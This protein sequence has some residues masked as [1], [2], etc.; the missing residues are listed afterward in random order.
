MKSFWFYLTNFIYK[1]PGLSG[2]K[3]VKKNNYKKS[4]IEFFICL[5]ASW[6]PIILQILIRMINSEDVF[7]EIV[8]KSLAGGEIY[9][10]ICS[11][12]GALIYLLIEFHYRD[13]KFP[14][15]V[16]FLIITVAAGILSLVIHTLNLTKQIHNHNLINSIS[17]LIYGITLFFWL[18]S[19][20]YRNI[21]FSY[22]DTGK[23]QLKQNEILKALEGFHE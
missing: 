18:L 2:L 21:E 8:K 17:L 1:V 22:A 9:I 19:I 15:F 23:E 14:D 20:L 11:L 5:V 13:S 7:L 10:Y 3:H 6:S 4:F 16:I 12:L